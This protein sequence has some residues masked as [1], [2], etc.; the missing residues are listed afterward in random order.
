MAELQ[1]RT[2]NLLAVVRNV[3]RRSI[4]PSPGLD[5][6][7][8]RLAALG[9]VQGFLSRST[10]YSVNLANVVQA[11]LEAVADGASDRVMV[12]GPELELPGESVQAVALALH[13]LATNE[14]H[15]GQ[16]VTRREQSIG[17]LWRRQQFDL[18]GQVHAN[19]ISA[20][21]MQAT[22]RERGTDPCE[23]KSPHTA[24]TLSLTANPLR[25]AIPSRPKGRGFSRR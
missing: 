13:E 17:L 11:E 25:P 5:E 24:P 20:R 4:D 18:Q 14:C 16:R 1:H 9:R 22:P 2:R 21:S 8:A 6:Y 15:Y 10:S 3:A 12:N 7:D 23:R 19:M